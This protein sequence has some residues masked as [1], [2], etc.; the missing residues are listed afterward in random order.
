MTGGGTENGPR[1]NL[2]DILSRAVS[3]AHSLNAAELAFL[4]SLRDEGAAREM[5][6]AAYALKLKHCGRGVAM[7]GLVEMGNV[8]AK[9]C[10]YCGIR[11]SNSLVGRYQ[12]TVDEIVRLARLNIAD[13]YASLV[14]Q[15]GEIESEAHTAFVEEC[16]RRIQAL[17]GGPLGITLSLGEQEES[18][19]ARWRAAGASRYLLR[20]ETSD[21]N[22]YSRLHPSSHSWTRRAACLDA[23][24]RCG[25]Q[26]GTGVMSGLPGQTAEDLARDILFF[27]EKDVDMIG[28]GPYLPH[29]DTPLGRGIALTPEYAAERLRLGL[30][31]ISATRLQL[32]DVNIA[33]TTA[34]QALAPDGRERGVLAGA[35]V[36]MPNLT[37]TGYRRSY[38]LYE[39]KPGLDEDSESARLALERS[40]AAIG[41]RVNYGVRG[42]SPHFTRGH[43]SLRS[44]SPLPIPRFYP[45]D[46]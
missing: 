25:Y 22:L 45:I 20:I 9:D 16:L 30:N 27:Q 14:L 8:C 7:R 13:R 24:R 34:L 42:D 38:Q 46:R 32:H 17:P 12:L 33:A 2:D 41:E 43:R 19:Y 5:R 21:R 36:M 11:K 35:N 31:M 3:A 37:D 23:L 1:M 44:H 18:V 29:R 40:L 4:V 15:S 28:M 10:L 39:N 6:A 26:V